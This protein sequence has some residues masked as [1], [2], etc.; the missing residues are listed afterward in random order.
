MTA[1]S[2]PRMSPLRIAL[3]PLGAALLL[4][5]L[6][7]P[8]AL[9]QPVEPPGPAALTP[10]QQQ[11]LLPEWRR[12]SLQA[13]RAQAAILRR[14]E[15][16]VAAAASVEALQ[17]CQWQ[18]RRDSMGQRREQRTAMRQLFER[19]GISL[20]RSREWPG[21]RDGRPL[22]RPPATSL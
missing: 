8:G 20:P 2:S 12:L 11:K 3:H 7:G 17:A 21:R 10:A 18:Q 1:P 16:C 15:A 13:V 4:A 6:S 22:E 19:H 14:Q 9:A 5:G